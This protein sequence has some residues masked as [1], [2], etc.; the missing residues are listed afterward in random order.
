MASRGS[1]SKASDTPAFARSPPVPVQ[2]RAYKLK[3][4]A[5]TEDFLTQVARISGKLLKGGDPDLNT[6]AR[7]E[8]A[9]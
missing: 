4:W 5:D 2:R 7:W 1:P 3:E 8:D 6:V 9:V